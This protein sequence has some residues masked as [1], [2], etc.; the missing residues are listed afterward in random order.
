MDPRAV[1]FASQADFEVRFEWGLQGLEAAAGGVA[2]VVVVDVLSFSTCVDVA[3]ARGAAILPFA[4]RDARAAEHARRHG[5]LLAVER[6]EPGLALSPASLLDIVPGTRLV[7]PSPNGSTLSLHA[8]APIVLAG[9]LRNRRAV[10]ACAARCGGPVL[11]LAAGERWPDGSLR[12]AA[13]DLLGAGAI[14]AALGGRASPEA[15]VAAAA[16]AGVGER[17]ADAIGG[18]ASAIELRGRG[19]GRDVSLA[20]AVDTSD[21]V[22][23]LLGEAYVA[24]AAGAGA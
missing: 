20:L 5:A 23:R 22:P 16:F 3:C 8:K 18:C 15:Q 2:A 13:E 9:C 10:A 1:D 21:C 7:L 24:A 19:H 17:L 6:G 4:H 11:V 12:P 14:I